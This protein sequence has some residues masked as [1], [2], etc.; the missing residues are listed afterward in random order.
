MALSAS[1]DPACVKLMHPQASQLNTSSLSGFSGF[2]WGSAISDY[3]RDLE[4]G[5]G[6]AQITG[7][8]KVRRLESKCPPTSPHITLPCLL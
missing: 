6:F 2:D 5:S 8:M 3:Y 7:L 1:L 4:E